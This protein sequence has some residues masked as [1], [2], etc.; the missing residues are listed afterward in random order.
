MRSRVEPRRPAAQPLDMQLAQLQIGAIQIRDLEFAARGRLQRLRQRRRTPVI[1]INAGHRIVRRRRLG[2]LQQIRHPALRVELHHAVALGILNVVAEHRGA[3]FA[4]GGR[5]QQLGEIRAVKN[6][7]AQNQRRRRAVQ[8]RLGEY[9]RLRDA[10]GGLLDD[11]LE[12]QSPL[13]AGSQKIAKRG[14]VARRR[15]DQIFP[16][17]GRHQRRQRVINHR[18]VVHRQSCLDSDIVIGCRRVPAPPA[19][20]IPFLFLVKI[21]FLIAALLVF[22]C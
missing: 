15:D 21:S 19:K 20:M 2:L 14:L 7:V 16:N 17:A 1:E 8:E 11:V 22:R 4:L 10:V 13:R 3:R 5:L 12:R 9:Q 18:L 6:V